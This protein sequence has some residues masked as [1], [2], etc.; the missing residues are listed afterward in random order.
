MRSTR[1]GRMFRVRD[2]I[3]PKKVPTCKKILQTRKA[4]AMQLGK[5]QGGKVAMARRSRGAAHELYLF[6]ILMVVQAR[7][8][9]FACIEH[10]MVPRLPRDISPPAPRE[11]ILL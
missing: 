5:Q 3:A 1:D 2:A 8:S 4:W 11:N 10:E 6:R 9:R 7:I